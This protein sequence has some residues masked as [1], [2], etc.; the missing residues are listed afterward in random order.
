MLQYGSSMMR[1]QYVGP[2]IGSV[3]RPIVAANVLGS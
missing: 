2:S 1:V 3:S